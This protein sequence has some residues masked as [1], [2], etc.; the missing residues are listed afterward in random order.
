MSVVC[1]GEALIDLVAVAESQFEARPGGCPMLVAVVLSRLGVPSHLWTRLSL[2]GFG[3][4]L[5]RHLRA[6]GVSERHLL[7]ADRPTSLAVVTLEADEPSYAFYTDGSATFDLGPAD[8]PALDHDTE[9]LFFGSL[10]SFLDP[11]ASATN[12][13]VER[14]RGTRIIVL[15]SH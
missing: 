14:E 9:A 13:L 12:A 2:D 5:L 8:V 3:R 15:R 10:A 1:A 11:V 7:Y 4:R 6:N